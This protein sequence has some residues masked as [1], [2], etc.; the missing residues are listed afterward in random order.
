[1]AIS[2]NGDGTRNVP[3]IKTAQPREHWDLRENSPMNG[4]RSMDG[5]PRERRKEKSFYGGVLYRVPQKVPKG[6][7]RMCRLSYDFRREWMS[8]RSPLDY[9][10]H[11]RPQH[12]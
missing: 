12:T 4:P 7:Q 11:R 3:F 2:T 6:V 8:A 9:A 1:M 10:C 5:D